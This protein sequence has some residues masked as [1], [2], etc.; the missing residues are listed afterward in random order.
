M[1]LNI[2]FT[3]LKLSRN[4]IV[5]TFSRFCTFIIQ[6]RPINK[7]YLIIQF[8]KHFRKRVLRSR[9]LDVW[10]FIEMGEIGNI[11][12]HLVS[13]IRC[14]YCNS[15]PNKYPL[16]DTLQVSTQAPTHNI[17]LL[18][19]AEC[20]RDIFMTECTNVYGAA[21]ARHV[22]QAPCD[23][24]N[25]VESCHHLRSHCTALLNLRQKIIRR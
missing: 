16:M 22:W 13:I 19:R 11:K 7:S 9:I 15:I 14:Q 17:Y 3:T 21:R 20:R 18:W 12:E 2:L 5:F 1:N 6:Q 25:H 8:W 23:A 4:T 10:T 24:M